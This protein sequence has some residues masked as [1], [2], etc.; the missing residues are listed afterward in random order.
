MQLLK[1]SLQEWGLNCEC[2]RTS[3]SGI[4][5]Q[6]KSY[7]EGGIRKNLVV[8]MP[9]KSDCRIFLLVVLFLSGCVSGNQMNRE[10]LASGKAENHRAAEAYHQKVEWLQDDLAA[11][12]QQADQLEARQVA[13]TAITYSYQL[14]DEYQLVRPAVL[15]NLLIRA[16]LKDRGLCYH[17]TEDLLKRLQAL[18][19]RTYQL[20]WG[21]AHRGSDLREHN[22][23][24]ITARGQGFE[25][26]MVLDPWRNSGDLFWALINTDQYPWRKLPP[27]EW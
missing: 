15:H 17:W 4:F 25:K 23:V 19:L 1:K 3:K 2:L 8:N 7:K 11:L 9:V 12:N 20:H 6:L 27:S 26:G 14:A 10:L 24:V 21:V 16:G 22:S 18:D 5:E 13:E